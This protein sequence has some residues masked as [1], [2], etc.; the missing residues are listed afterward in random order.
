MEKQSHQ[1]QMISCHKCSLVTC[2]NGDLET[3][4]LTCD[5]EKR[6]ERQLKSLSIFHYAKR[7]APSHF[8]TDRETYTFCSYFVKVKLLYDELQQNSR[9][10]HI[11]L[12]KLFHKCLLTQE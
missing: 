5:G 4:V 7:L 6:G 11:I 12:N 3:I 2:Y 9:I 10:P 1:V 8:P